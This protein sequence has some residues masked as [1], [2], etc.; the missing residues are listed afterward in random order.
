VLY[1]INAKTLN[2]PFL[3]LIYQEQKILLEQIEARKGKQ[4]PGP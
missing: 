3:D 1:L 2:R 4:L